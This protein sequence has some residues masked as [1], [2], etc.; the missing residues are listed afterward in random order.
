M[1]SV[2]FLH[3]DG[4][5]RLRVDLPTRGRAE[6]AITAE[7]V[8]SAILRCVVDQAKEVVEGQHES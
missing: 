2:L 1:K 4:A 7:E 5:V 3:W 6:R 8:P